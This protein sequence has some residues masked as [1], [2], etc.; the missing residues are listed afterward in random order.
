M[1]S[2]LGTYNGEYAYNIPIQ[3]LL[4]FWLKL[5]KCPFKVSK[6]ES[7]CIQYVLS[8]RLDSIYSN[9]SCSCKGPRLTQLRYIRLGRKVEA[10]MPSQWAFVG[11]QGQW[12]CHANHYGK[13]SDKQPNKRTGNWPESRTQLMSKGLDTW[14]FIINAALGKNVLGE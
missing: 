11:K 2:I 6:C 14:P 12:A 1:S 4:Q 10:R 7:H 9:C 5:G 13:K 8:W 3:R